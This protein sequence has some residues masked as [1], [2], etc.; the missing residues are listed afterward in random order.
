MR[1][2]SMEELLYRLTDERKMLRDLCL[3]YVNKKFF[4][5]AES[6][7]QQLVGVEEFTEA[8]GLMANNSAERMKLLD[9]I[10]TCKYHTTKKEETPCREST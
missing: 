5:I 8:V 4:D 3:Q 1:A 6:Y 7:Y 10:Y 2:V 9:H